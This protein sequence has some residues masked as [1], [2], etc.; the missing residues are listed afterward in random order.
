MK[1]TSRLSFVLGAALIASCLF[2]T[3][4]TCVAQTAPT[5]EELQKKLEDLEKQLAEVKA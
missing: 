5:N 1:K 3:A 4:A 2:G